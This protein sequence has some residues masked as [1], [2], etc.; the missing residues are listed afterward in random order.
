[1]VIR[2]IH[3]AKVL[4]KLNFSPNS[5]AGGIMLTSSNDV[6]L[7]CYAHVA[8]RITIYH[9]FKYLYILNHIPQTIERTLKS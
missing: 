6:N 3:N 5:R 7:L 8:D 9:L 1:M 2:P 4:A